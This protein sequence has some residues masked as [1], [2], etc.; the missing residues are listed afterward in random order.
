MPDR[1]LDLD[2]KFFTLNLARECVSNFVLDADVVVIVVVV[3][4]AVVVFFI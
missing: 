1:R 2:T 3:A 4:T